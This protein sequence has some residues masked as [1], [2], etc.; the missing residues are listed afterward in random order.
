MIFCPNI[1]H[2]DWVNAVQA[3]GK[4]STLLLYDKLGGRIP[5]PK[6]VEALLNNDTI[7]PGHNQR[8]WDVNIAESL[9]SNWQTVDGLRRPVIR[10]FVRKAADNKLMELRRKYYKD[11][12]GFNLSAG[13]KVNNIWRHKILPYDKRFVTEGL[14]ELHL[15]RNFQREDFAAEEASREAETQS[16]P[17]KGDIRPETGRDVLY[18]VATPEEINNVKVSAETVNQLITAFEGMGG[19]LRLTSIIQDAEGN[20][21]DAINSAANFLEGTIDMRTDTI[22]KRMKAYQALPEEVAHW[23]YRLLKDQDGLKKSLAESVKSHPEYKDILSDPDYKKLY[24]GDV[25]ALTEEAIGRVIAR[26]IRKVQLDQANT[27]EK[28]FVEK[29]LEWVSS[30]VGSFL[31][32][33]TETVTQTDFEIAAQRILNSDLVNLMTVGEYQEMLKKANPVEAVEEVSRAVSRQFL[34]DLVDTEI[35]ND[36]KRVQDRL[37]QSKSKWLPRTLKKVLDQDGIK[38][39]ISTTTS[40][41]LHG[42]NSQ[43]RRTKFDKLPE[44]ETLVKKAVYIDKPSITFKSKSILLDKYGKAGIPLNSPLSL[45]VKKEELDML[46]HVKELIKKE[47]PKA[48][49]LPVEEFITEVENYISLMFDTTVLVTTNDPQKEYRLEGVIN[50]DFTYNETTDSTPY[51]SRY[52]FYLND[53]YV[54]N[55]HNTGH[56][57]TVEGKVLNGLVWYNFLRATSASTGTEVITLHEIQSDF[58]E[59]IQKEIKERVEQKLQEL[60]DNDTEITPTILKSTIADV[61]KSMKIRAKGAIKAKELQKK[62]R[63]IAQA[64]SNSMGRDGN[65]HANFIHSLIFETSTGNLLINPAQGPIKDYDEL[66]NILRTLTGVHGQ[67][68][69]EINYALRALEESFSYAKSHL[70]DKLQN[71]EK[72]M[73]S[74]YTVLNIWQDFVGTRIKYKEEWSEE[75]KRLIDSV[76][77]TKKEASESRKRSRELGQEVSQQEKDH[78]QSRIEGSIDRFAYFVSEQY[79]TEPAIQRYY[80]SILVFLLS[81]VIKNT[82][83]YNYNYFKAAVGNSK[84]RGLKIFINSAKRQY[85]VEAGRI[86]GTLKALDS[87]LAILKIPSK[88]F[89]ASID[90]LEENAKNILSTAD[91][92]FDSIAE[93]VF[94][95]EWAERSSEKENILT[96]DNENAY[97]TFMSNYRTLI[98]H[99]AIQ[100]YLQLKKDNPN[101][102]DFYFAGYDATNV[103]QGNHTTAALYAGPEE[104]LSPEKIPAVLS[105]MVGNSGYLVSGLTPGHVAVSLDSTAENKVEKEINDMIAESKVSNA[106]ELN[107]LFNKMSEY[108]LPHYQNSEAISPGETAKDK[109]KAIMKIYKQYSVGQRGPLSEGPMYLAL[110]KIPGVKLVYE[111]SPVIKDQKAYRVDL[112]GYQIPKDSSGKQALML[113]NL[114]KPEQV[115]T[116]EDT[117]TNDLLDARINLLRSKLPVGTEIIMDAELPSIARLEGKNS[118]GNAIIRLNPKKLLE[119]TLGHEFG[120]ILIDL[121]GGMSN[122]MIRVGRQQLVG[123]DL[124]AQVMEAYPDHVQAEDERID[125]EILATAV[126]MEVARLFAEEEK[127][128]KFEKWLVRFFRVV[129]SKVGIE[130][131]VARELAERLVYD[132]IAISPQ[133]V[134]GELSEYAQESRELNKEAQEQKSILARLIDKEEALR[135]QALHALE[136]KIG[137]YQSRGRD[138]DA[139]KDLKEALKYV[140]NGNPTQGILEFVRSALDQTYKVKA[141]LLRAK[142][143]D[144]TG[145]E[146]IEPKDLDTWRTYVSAYDM[147]ESYRQALV[148]A[149]EDMSIFGTEE[150]QKAFEMLLQQNALSFSLLKKQFGDLY[151][152]AAKDVNY[153]KG[154]T[155]II[156][157]VLPVL[158]KIIETK[159]EI[160]N[161]YKVKGKELMVD[162]LAPHVTV[163]EAEMREAEERKWRAIPYEQRQ[164]QD[165]D[166]I[167]LAKLSDLREE[168][169]DKTRERL[170]KEL[171]LAADDI[172]FL[173]RH[174]DTMLDSPDV[175]A[176]VIAKIYVTEMEKTRRKIIEERYTFI[177]MVEALEKQQGRDFTTADETLFDFMLEEDENMPGKVYSQYLISNVPSLLKR[178]YY[179]MIEA[180]ETSGVDNSTGKKLSSYEKWLRKEEWRKK[181]APR[182]EEAWLNAQDEFIDSLRE[183]KLVTTKQA[184]E[185]KQNI[186][187]KYK[188]RKKNSEIFGEDSAASMEVEYFDRSNFW[189]YRELSPYYKKLNKKWDAF[190]KIRAAGMINGKQTDQRVLFYDF[191]LEK[192]KQADDLL[193]GKYRLGNKLPGVVK[194]MGDRMR[195]N[196]GVWRT[197]KRE[198]IDKFQKRGSD[199]DRGTVSEQ[200]KLELV[201]EANEPVYL[202]PIHYTNKVDL[203]DQSF[204]VATIY[205]N[206]LRMSMEYDTLRDLQ[207]PF[208]M[209]GNFIKER[210]YTKTNDMGQ[211]VK[212]A[213]SRGKTEEDANFLDKPG[214]EAHTTA[215]FVDFMKMNLYGMRK[216]EE[217]DW[218]ILG[219]KIDQA[220]FLDGINQYTGLSLLGFN[221]IQGFSNIVLG[222]TMQTI[223]ARAGEFF[224][225]KNLH[226]ATMM[227]YANLGG[228]MAD[229][230]KR[231]PN[232]ILSLL[233]DAFDTLGDYAGGKINKNSR[234]RELFATS[235]AFFLSHAGE[236]YMQTRAVLAMLD[237]MVALDSDGKELGSMLKQFS[238]ENGRLKLNDKVANFNADQQAAFKGKLK[239]ILARMHG[240]YSREGMSAIQMYSFGRM[241]IMFRKFVVPGAKRRWQG[242][243][244]NELLGEYTEG[245]YVTFGRVLPQL[246]KDLIRL[247][248]DILSKNKSQLTKQEL[249]NVVRTLNELAALSAVIIL[250][251]LAVRAVENDDGDDNWLNHLAYQSLRLRSE[252]AFFI[253]PTE[254]MK[255]LK[256]PAASMASLETLIKLIGD[257]SHPLLSGTLQFDVYEAGTW[258]DHYKIEKTLIQGTP[259]LKQFYRIK[260]IKDQISVF[261]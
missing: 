30:I 196:E 96:A 217:Q 71:V 145:E 22:E 185:F 259:G 215:Q 73:E 62:G 33:K 205:F 191:I 237:R 174:L 57:P 137:I 142:R 23:W 242:K 36:T 32:S 86:T 209:A 113:Y 103:L 93:E 68:E 45:A 14:A 219:L 21:V 55:K 189:N 253:M 13:E 161:Y 61:V 224:G 143:K 226:N 58:F 233:N 106:K 128:T 9:I 35:Q 121:L 34:V 228:T 114:D 50:S 182:N 252:L 2:P 53:K 125:K 27:K 250:G 41:V 81:E 221:V 179:D 136:Q 149:R 177:E 223:E 204:D 117:E 122:P 243:R 102:G 156:D 172:G 165:F 134:Q 91:F 40:R 7:T 38:D 210:K 183:R 167:W 82:P 244:Y 246:M 6:E 193:P 155:T 211:K 227:Y 39:L 207:A 104:L 164:G 236:H 16:T 152:A 20:L 261:K 79:S 3:L 66:D 231:K 120:H 74:T 235:T 116:K 166:M 115:S 124:E 109:V 89:E 251:M 88:E 97:Q 176:S 65:E 248:F 168:I 26:H 52:K 87:K 118:Q 15:T 75:Y 59:E 198:S 192:S 154:S 64:F 5:S 187:K 11:Q 127:R 18:N 203:N 48:T 80:K 10:D 132:D 213:L 201:N 163:V 67:D 162:F 130:I 56:S 241:A 158:D 123:S 258:K 37:L 95:K 100:N 255:I 208:E 72:H 92:Y 199:T 54:V 12:I 175:V 229:I 245:N 133:E 151:A 170:S 135:I 77:H 139:I 51:H 220:K 214:S 98:Y 238:V 99:H 44:H 234:F 42:D 101:T 190:E 119:D 247:K 110:S 94:N 90:A 206:F 197:I 225:T 146:K 157:Q 1:K 129:R 25:N 186:R 160:K 84:N 216:A 257:L 148:E 29:F 144:R 85:K 43:P 239:R 47:N 200:G 254:A 150:D 60:E 63:M 147:L 180:L 4:D 31:N 111:N 131:S 140:E 240:E 28:N 17:F 232:N 46:N 173:S 141:R 138:L 169:T 230:G 178:D 202:L 112:S 49:T 188:L 69:R 171:D 126:G 105:D 218:H 83:A 195:A 108:L 256:S 260:N 19:S 249:A 76:Y 107:Q 78:Y 24:E 194:S 8:V 181:W 70:Q 222:E 184:A 212:N 159:N 153:K